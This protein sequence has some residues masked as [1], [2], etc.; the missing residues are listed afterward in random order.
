MSG[1]MTQDSFPGLTCTSETSAI[2][3]KNENH[4]DKKPSVIITL[5]SPYLIVG[6]AVSQ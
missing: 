4:I 6:A 5:K 1:S 3:L 2:T